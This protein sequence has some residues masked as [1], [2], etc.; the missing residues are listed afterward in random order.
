MLCTIRSFQRVHVNMVYTIIE[1]AAG[2]VQAFVTGSAFY[3]SPSLT[4]GA[5]SREGVIYF[6]LL[7]YPLMEMA[8][9][10]FEHR[11][12]LHKHKI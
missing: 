3:N 5:L 4:D 1:T 11:S 8:N 12:I 2:T 7:Y 10:S 9:I 6:A